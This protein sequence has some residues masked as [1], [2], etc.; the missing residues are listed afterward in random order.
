MFYSMFAAEAGAKS[1]FGCDMS[2]TM[3]EMSCDVVLTNQLAD[4]INLIHSKSTDLKIPENL[5][6]K[7]VDLI[8]KNLFNSL[9]LF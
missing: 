2:K 1:V 7:S 3:Y 6:E 8:V 4:Q 9:F 5:P